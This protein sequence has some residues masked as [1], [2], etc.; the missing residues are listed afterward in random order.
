MSQEFR[1]IIQVGEEEYREIP[2]YI[3][4]S[5]V[6]GLKDYIQEVIQEYEQNKEDEK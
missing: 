3:P 5:R 4:V 6:N 2:L 1:I